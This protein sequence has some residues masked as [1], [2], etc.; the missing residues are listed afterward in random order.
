MTYRPTA[1]GADSVLPT[2]GPVSRPQANTSLSCKVAFTL[3]PLRYRITP[4]LTRLSDLASISVHIALV[5]FVVQL[6]CCGSAVYGAW[7][8]NPQ[9]RFL[10]VKFLIDGETHYGWVR[11]KVTPHTNVEIESYAYETVADKP[12]CAREVLPCPAPDGGKETGQNLSNGPSLGML[13]LG[14]D[15]LDLWRREALA[16]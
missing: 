12:I 4:F 15:G 6:I 16:F 13:A 3:S 2:S 9:N 1:C 5:L 8:D 7:G 11:M 10:G 14:A